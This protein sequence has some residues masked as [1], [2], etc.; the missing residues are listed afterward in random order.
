MAEVMLHAPTFNAS[1]PLRY[2]QLFRG[3]AVIEHA[4]IIDRCGA[5]A[6]H[7][8]LWR[9]T[10]QGVAIACMVT[11]DH[12]WLLSFVC[13]ALD[14]HAINMT[15]AHVYVRVCPHGSDLVSLL[16]LRREESPERPVVDSDVARIAELVGG[17]VT[18]ELTLEAFPPESRRAM[19]SDAATLTRFEPTGDD[20]T[21]LLVV[22]TRDRPGIFR[23]VTDAL[24]GAHVHIVKSLV[25]TALE[26]NVVRRFILREEDGRM[27]DA[28]RRSRLQAHVLRA[29]NAVALVSPGRLH[30]KSTVEISVGRSVEGADGGKPH[31]SSL[32]AT[33]PPK[34]APGA[35]V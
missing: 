31:L 4:A 10:H 23:A 16:W 6:A 33:V 27:P 15:A 5:G 28:Y 25:A 2:R 3:A 18:G 12:P 24:L 11:R 30:D 17:L 14:A 7:A 13:T 8:E 9:R 1:M 32:A 19:P 20:T 29:I 22:E 26:G 34:M 35:R 21:A